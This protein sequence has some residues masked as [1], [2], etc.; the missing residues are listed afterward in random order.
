MGGYRQALLSSMMSQY[1]HDVTESDFQTAVLERSK[2]VPVVVDFWA[3]W[4]GPCR[5]LGPLL[6]RVATEEAGS[7][8][9]AKVDVDANPRLAQAFGVQSIPMVVAFKDGKP[10]SSFVG[11]VPEQAV[12]QFVAALV[13]P[14]VDPRIVEAEKLAEDGFASTAEDRLTDI[15]ATEPTNVEAALVLAGLLIDRGA[16]EEALALLGRQAPTPEVK[17][18]EAAARLLA[19]GTIDLDS[20]EQALPDLLA[21]V[22]NGGDD[23]AEARQTMLDIFELL[24]NDHPLTAQ[25]RRQLAN[26]LF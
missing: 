11:A 19:A 1:V 10:V 21:K 15:L 2:E 24:G 17:R 12:R 18:L 26:A 4:C 22:T 9:L 25:Y 8:E 5:T 23:R 16:S 7:F 14:A 6:E 13:P 3:A 20:P